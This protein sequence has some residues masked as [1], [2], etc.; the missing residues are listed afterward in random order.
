VMPFL[1]AGLASAR[2]AL[3]GVTKAAVAFIA[4]PIGAV[5]ALLA[6]G[7]LLVQNAMSRSE[8]TTNKLSKAFSVFG[9][10]ISKLLSLLEPLGEFI[11]D[12]LVKGL[13]LLEE[14]FYLAMEGM[15][16]A[17]N[18]LGFDDAAASVREF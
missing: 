12:G 16:A 11:V 2:T 9:G 6:S 4:T 3:L 15:A 18:L 17:L 13:E 8:E 10:F 14:S 1:A 5:I 7:F